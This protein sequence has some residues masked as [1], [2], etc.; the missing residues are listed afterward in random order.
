MVR[1]TGGGIDIHK[2]EKV[3]LLRKKHGELLVCLGVSKRRRAVISN[4]ANIDYY[5][6][7]D[8]PIIS[9]ITG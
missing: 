3:M 1:I 8:D 7:M 4:R 9:H 6:I 5:L 2:G